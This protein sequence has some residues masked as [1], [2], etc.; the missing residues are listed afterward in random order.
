MQK[1]AHRYYTVRDKTSRV[2]P[3]RSIFSYIWVD[4]CRVGMQG[5]KQ[6][7]QA[8]L[9]SLLLGLRKHGVAASRDTGFHDRK[10][11]IRLAADA[12][13]ANARGADATRWSRTMLAAS[14]ELPQRRQLT[15]GAKSASASSK[16][17][18]EQVLRIRRR[19]HRP[20][21][22]RKARDSA[23]VLARAM[24]RKRTKVL[25]GLVPGAEGL[26][27]ECTLLQET[28]D[29]AVCLKAQ[30]DVMQLLVRALQAAKVP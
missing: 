12:A 25:K 14:T 13:L 20:R 15:R 1:V 18:C 9:E 8:L 5:S 28:L 27:D 21:R 23:G 16:L 4:R 17:I 11:A 3:R 10:R 24:A 6:F 19:S 29:Y 26:D 30:V 2:Q 7:K 22:P